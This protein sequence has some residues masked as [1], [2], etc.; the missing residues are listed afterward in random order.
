MTLRSHQRMEQRSVLLIT[1]KSERV[2]PG[3]PYEGFTSPWATSITKIVVCQI[4]AKV[5]ESYRHLIRRMVR[6]PHQGNE[7]P[8]RPRL[9]S[10]SASSRIAV[11]A[12]AC[13]HAHN[14]LWW[15]QTIF[16]LKFRVFLGVNI[17]SN[18][19]Y[20]YFDAI[21][22]VSFSINAA[23]PAPTGPATPF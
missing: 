4:R 16:S 6:F 2:I 3:P 5:A 7:S 23:L 20:A 15:K 1:S 8:F 9:L 21:S 14:S 22:R 17:V 13:S 12:T 19:C 18:D 11:R 10:S